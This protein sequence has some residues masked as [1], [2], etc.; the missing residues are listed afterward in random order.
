M[1]KEK[2]VE[3]VVTY[4]MTAKM[5]SFE[6]QSTVQKRAFKFIAILHV[7]TNVRCTEAGSTGW[8]NP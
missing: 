2:A 5:L 1:V 7:Y 8:I 3:A 4:F 6:F